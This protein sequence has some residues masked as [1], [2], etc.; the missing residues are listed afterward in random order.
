MC[1]SA[2]VHMHVCTCMSVHIVC[3]RVCLCMCTYARVCVHMVCYVV[4]MYVSNVR[5][6]LDES[7]EATP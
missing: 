5:Y 6:P 3:V 4:Y 7:T 2:C 1:V